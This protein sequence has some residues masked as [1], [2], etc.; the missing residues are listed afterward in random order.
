LWGRKPEAQK[1]PKDQQK[2][3][4]TAENRIVDNFFGLPNL[5]TEKGR[6]SGKLQSNYNLKRGFATQFLP[7]FSFFV[8]G[9][10]KTASIEAV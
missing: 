2:H 6:K 7:L 10:E 4:K 1:P 5:R 9:N 8:A 3:S